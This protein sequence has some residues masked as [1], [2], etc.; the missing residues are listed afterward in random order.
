ML[1][2]PGR[3][4]LR[5][6]VIATVA[7]IVFRGG[8]ATLPLLLA[9][10][11]GRSNA[12]DVYFFAWAVFS[13]AGSLVFTAYKDSPL[14]PVL[15]EEKLA[16]PEGLPRLLGSILAHTWVL[17]GALAVVVGIGALGWFTYQYRGPD[18]ALARGMVIPFTLY[19]VATATRTFFATLL[20]VEHHFVVQSIA[21]G[22]GMVAM[23][24][25]LFLG[26]AMVGVLLVPVAALAGE[27][28][29]SWVLAW[30]AIRIVG[31]EVQLCFDRPE[32]L[33]GFV[34]LVGHQIGGGAVTRINPVVDQL[35]AGLAGVVGAGTMLRFSGEIALLPTS[36]MQAALLPVLLSHLSDDFARRDYVTLR[37]SVNRSL[38]TVTALLVVATVVLHLI[39]F[40]LLR[41]V[42]L[43]GEMDAAGV[44][45]MAVL[46]PY[47][48]VGLA[49]FGALLILA[50]AH[51]A[52]KNTGIFV[53]I[54]ILNAGSNA[55]LNVVLLSAIGLEGLAL[56][57]S[58]V[59]TIIA[60]LF[61]ILFE[62]RV[63]ATMAAATPKAA[64][65]T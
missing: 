63:R 21:S 33:R 48:L 23:L 61:W 12:M 41:F 17:G 43:H 56:S 52:L 34:K 6:T 25:T 27:L 16:R 4:L 53:G 3:S 65:A 7:Q 26:H 39:R 47:H 54:G 46:L 1:A 49:P 60:V 64:E 44:D 28:V 9:Y 2:P 15:A 30:Y 24:G 18:L 5:T 11:F 19:L 42:F 35:M 8:E 22:I 51:I 32:A 29:V 31:L 62:R 50:R 40:P 58:L 14:V 13:F 57:T 59:H 55:V 37:R 38:L 10:W 36:L 45:R 20:S